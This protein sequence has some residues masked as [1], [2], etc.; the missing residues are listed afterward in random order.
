MDTYQIDPQG[1]DDYGYQK[2]SSDERKRDWIEDIAMAVLVIGLI[3]CV[4][5]GALLL[6]RYV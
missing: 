1:Y 3:V 2:R 4:T 6:G 5:F